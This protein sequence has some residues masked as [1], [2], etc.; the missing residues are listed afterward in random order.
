MR[1]RSLVGLVPCLLSSPAFAQDATAWS[2]SASGHYVR[3]FGHGGAGVTLGIARR[4]LPHLQLGVPLSYSSTGLG[5]LTRHRQV[6]AVGT[7]LIYVPR[8]SG[9]PGGFL[10]V[11]ASLVHSNVPLRTYAISGGPPQD[12]IQ[13]GTGLGLGIRSGLGV[14]ITRRFRAIFTAGVTF[15]SIYDEGNSAIWTVGLGFGSN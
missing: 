14:P 12:R 1:L 4:L 3:A 11:G 7:E 6:L 9:R 8:E 5:D 13:D 10:A 15:H 2:W